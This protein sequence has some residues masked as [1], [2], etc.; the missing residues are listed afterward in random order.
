MKTIT[1]GANSVPTS[2]TNAESKKESFLN[3]FLPEECKIKSSSDFWY[4]NA[5]ALVCAA[6][7]FPPL[8]IG[9][10]ICVVKAKKGGVKNHEKES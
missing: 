1:P 3:F 10:A 7:I 6:F 9:A 4:V 8:I 5:I 2:G